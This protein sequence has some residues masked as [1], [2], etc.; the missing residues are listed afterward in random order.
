[1]TNLPISG[2]GITPRANDLFNLADKEKDD[3]INTCLDFES[4]AKF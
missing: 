4:R 1:M 2:L 3:L